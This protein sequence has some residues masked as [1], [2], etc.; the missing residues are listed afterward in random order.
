L[1]NQETVHQLKSAKKCNPGS[2]WS[3]SQTGIWLF[4]GTGSEASVYQSIHPTTMCQH[5]PETGN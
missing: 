5:V 4:G 1:H 3:H 2:T